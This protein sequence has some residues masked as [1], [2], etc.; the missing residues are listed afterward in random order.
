[1]G[2]HFYGRIRI[3]GELNTHTVMVF[4]EAAGFRG[5]PDLI[6]DHLEDGRF[7]LENED[8]LGGMFYD[9]ELFCRKHDLS[10][11]RE[12]AGTDAC[13]PQVSF[14]VPGM[15]SP[16]T[17]P[18]DAWGTLM[19]SMDSVQTV[20]EF[21]DEGNVQEAREY[22]HGLLVELPELPSFQVQPYSGKD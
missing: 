9:L 3:G 10:Y 17:V 4:C 5:R 16:R 18:V 21:L 12:S 13:S 22:L 20:K 8:A 14:W 1:M 7:V 15:G 19:V 2:D 6:E 11:I